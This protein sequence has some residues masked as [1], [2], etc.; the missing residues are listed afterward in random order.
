MSNQPKRP[1][2]TIEFGDPI[3]EQLREQITKEEWAYPTDSSWDLPDE[4]DEDIEP[5]VMSGTS[6]PAKDPDATPRTPPTERRKTLRPEGMLTGDSD[7]TPEVDP[8]SEP[9]NLMDDDLLID[10]APS[11]PQVAKS[12]GR[13]LKPLTSLRNDPKPAAERKPPAERKPSADLKHLGPPPPRNQPPPPKNKPIL[14]GGG[15]G[16]G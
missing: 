13:L 5:P 2:H 10:S 16:G 14:G 3:R 4:D 11:D 1:A 9:L 12:M 6:M 8:D 15:G 7:K